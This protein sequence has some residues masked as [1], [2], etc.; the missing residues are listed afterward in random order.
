MNKEKFNNTVQDFTKLW[1]SYFTPDFVRHAVAI[2]K[3]DLNKKIVKTMAIK[4]LDW[5]GKRLY[6]ARVKSICDIETI[7]SNDDYGFQ[8][9]GGLEL[10]AKTDKNTPPG[11]K[12]FI[13]YLLMII[14]SKDAEITS[15]KTHIIN[16]DEEIIKIANDEIF[17]IEARNAIKEKYN[18]LFKIEED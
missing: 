18:W 8:L 17:P 1:E 3:R 2:K 15:L 12:R 4:L 10:K 14:D 9:G 6:I 11:I 13:A 16:S 7:T 5:F